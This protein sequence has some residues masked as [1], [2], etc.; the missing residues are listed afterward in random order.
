M[1]KKVIDLGLLPEKEAAE[2]EYDGFIRNGLMTQLVRIKPGKEI[3]EAHMR[4]RS[5]IAHWVYEKGRGEKVIELFKL[6][7]K[8][9]VKINNYD[10]LRLLFGELLKEIQRVKSEGDFDGGKKIVEENGVKVDASLHTELLDRYSKLKLA[11]YTGFVN[12]ML[13]PVYDING[14]ITE[15]KVEYIDD[16]LSQMM[17]YGKN[18]SFLPAN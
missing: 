18:Y 11:P 9:Y 16:Y 8:T 12:P 5:A 2:A 14:E 13:I 15:I 10:K 7:G 4:G 17:Y 3:E 6:N 1:D